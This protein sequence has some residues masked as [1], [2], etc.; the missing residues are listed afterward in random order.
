MILVFGANGQLGTDLVKRLSQ[1]NKDFL[2]ITRDDIDIEKTE[3]LKE[4]LNKKKYRFL[5]NCTGYHKTEEVEENP[6]KAFTVNARV[7]EIMAEDASSKNA[8][9]FHISTDYVFGAV[10]QNTLLS[11]ESAP[12]PLNIYGSS[13]LMGENLIKSKINNYYILRVASLFGLSG[14]SD[15][16]GNFVEAIISKAKKGE[17]IKVVD[18]QI[19]SPTYTDY[20]AEA[21]I[22]MM[23]KSVDFG[24]YNIVNKGKVSWYE[25]ANEIMRNLHFKNEI[26]KI[27]SSSI[28][29]KAKRPRFS[30]LSSN[31]IERAGFKV[32]T[33]QES[34]KTYLKL[35][36]YLKWKA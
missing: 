18:D 3:E 34:L 23:N 28:N 11:E 20:I 5:I 33:Y 10:K 12:G 22:F 19:M 35:K 27:S 14:T 16:G 25:F 31:K 15:K 9:F 24:I 26:K 30:A 36:G 1:N 8:V 17:E 2:P 32:P 13:K 7:P 4:F 6:A 21:I 29:L